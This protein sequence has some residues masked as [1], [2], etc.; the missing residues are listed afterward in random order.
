MEVGE[1]AFGLP[2][3]EYLIPVC[4]VGFVVSDWSD[5]VQCIVS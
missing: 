1:G 2:Y 4:L 3:G 5:G